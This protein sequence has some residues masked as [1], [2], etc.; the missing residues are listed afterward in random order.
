MT[1]SRKFFIQFSCDCDCPSGTPAGSPDLSQ[2]APQ[3]V[4]AGG[5]FVIEKVGQQDR[6][7]LADDGEKFISAPGTRCKVGKNIETA[8]KKALERAQARERRR[9]PHQPQHRAPAWCAGKTRQ[10]L[11]DAHDRRELRLSLRLVTDRTP[12]RH[13]ALGRRKSG[14]FKRKSGCGN[15]FIERLREGMKFRQCDRGICGLGR[16]FFDRTR[17]ADNCAGRSAW[18][19]SS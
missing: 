8:F 4:G 15:S 1:P 5:R 11:A 14:I 12:G 18:S 7:A 10:L 9:A 6:L 17:N 13:I 3:L 16:I 2:N 19:W